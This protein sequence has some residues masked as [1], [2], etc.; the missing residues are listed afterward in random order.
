MGQ[1]R[2]S[3]GGRL[4]RGSRHMAAVVGPVA[5]IPLP[6]PCSEPSA[7]PPSPSS[8]ATHSGT[9]PSGAHPGRMR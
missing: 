9:A 6:M 3:D 8:D 5:I 7:P 1:Y 4:F 2:L